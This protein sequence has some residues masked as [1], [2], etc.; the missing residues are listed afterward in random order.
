MIIKPFLSFLMLMMSL[1]AY[2]QQIEGI[3]RFKNAYTDVL[4]SFSET[5]YRAI[6]T[7]SVLIYD[8][9]NAANDSDRILQINLNTGTYQ[10]KDG[11][12]LL[13]SAKG[14]DRYG[15]HSI[16]FSDSGFYGVGVENTSCFFKKLPMPQST[17]DSLYRRY[18]FAPDPGTSYYRSSSYQEYRFNYSKKVVLKNISNGKTKTISQKKGMVFKRLFIDSMIGKQVD[19]VYQEIQGSIDSIVNGMVYIKAYYIAAYN[20]YNFQLQYDNKKGRTQYSIHWSIDTLLVFPIGQ[21]YG[22]YPSSNQTGMGIG[23]AVITLATVNLLVTPVYSIDYKTYQVNKPLFKRSLW[24]SLGAI[25]AGIIELI[26][27]PV[28]PEYQ[29][30]RV[31]PA[32]DLWILLDVKRN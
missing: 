11:K 9:T 15:Y 26:C 1:A 19:T 16:S 22:L 30:I 17:F 24:I 31:D 23:A 27:V 18:Q 7:D 28:D 3:Y 8:L 21:L 25:A 2:S 6:I 10:L 20:H 14:W 4:Y 13:D 5:R 12:L 29:T 32:E